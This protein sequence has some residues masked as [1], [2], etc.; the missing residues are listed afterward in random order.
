MHPVTQPHRQARGA[1]KNQKKHLASFLVVKKK[2]WLW[3][4]KKEEK[5]IFC[6]IHV[7]KWAE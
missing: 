7:K 6:Q 5:K 3:K 1:I 4:K 2:S